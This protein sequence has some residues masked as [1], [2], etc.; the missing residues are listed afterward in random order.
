MEGSVRSVAAP[1]TQKPAS[2]PTRAGFEGGNTRGDIAIQALGEPVITKD[3]GRIGWALEKGYLDSANV[4]QYWGMDEKHLRGLAALGVVW[5]NGKQGVKINVDSLQNLAQYKD[6]LF[7]EAFLPVFR[8]SGLGETKIRELFD[9]LWELARNGKL[10][11]SAWNELR[12]AYGLPKKYDMNPA[13]FSALL[14]GEK[15]E[16]FSDDKRVESVLE[17]AQALSNLILTMQTRFPRTGDPKKDLEQEKEYFEVFGELC[18]AKNF[19]IIYLDKWDNAAVQMLA[20]MKGRDPSRLKDRKE[21]LEGIKN[22]DFDDTL[23]EL[24]KK[25]KSW[26]EF[27]VKLL[28]YLEEAVV[29]GMPRKGMDSFQYYLSLNERMKFVKTILDEGEGG[30]RWK[31]FIRELSNIFKGQ[32][33]QVRFDYERV[34]KGGA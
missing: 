12:E 14:G 26:E 28:R 3:K 27:L 18:E 11:R 5:Q 20:Q 1:S 32:D 8:G 25:T 7:K 16:F 19:N 34:Q 9:K 17:L 4:Q 6:K 30:A 22:G 13:S 21:L 2:Q 31:A 23:K 29:K 33:N 15:G 10:D 24:A